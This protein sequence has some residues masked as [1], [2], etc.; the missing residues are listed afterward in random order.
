MKLL[1]TS[2]AYEK[3]LGIGKEFLKLVGKK[4]SKIKVFVVSTA[5]KRDKDW[6]WVK[7]TVSE[8][9]KI[10]LVKEN[11]SIFSLDR[12]VRKEE[13]K[14]TDVIY[15][16]GGNAFVY[17]DK[18]RKTGLD[19]IIKELVKKGKVYFGVSAGSCIPCPTI[20]MAVWKHS[21]RNTVNLKNLKAL[22]LVPF[23][24][25]AHYEKKYYSIISKAAL[26]TKYPIISINDRQAVL[27][28]GEKIK[29]I[30]RGKKIV[31]NS[32]NGF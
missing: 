4:P 17:L 13:L 28:K 23:L 24:V 2:T 20:E 29:I 3:N 11:I 19:K 30:G 15:V 1:L 25:T 22:N 18:I 10:G 26:K 21:D 8:L 27:V 32:Q 7:L 6:K 16:C 5:K 31:F 9:E 14:D 12:K